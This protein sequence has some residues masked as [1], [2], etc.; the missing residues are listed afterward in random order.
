[1][2]MRSVMQR[3]IMQ[4]GPALCLRRS[5]A[6]V[7]VGDQS[8]FDKLESAG[9]K[10]IFYFTATWCPP[11][12]MI[13]PIFE[14]LAKVRT[15]TQRSW[16]SFVAS[17]KHAPDSPSFYPTSSQP[18]LLPFLR[19]QYRRSMR[20]WTS[21][22]WMWMTSQRLRA[23]TRCVDRPCGARRELRGAREM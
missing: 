13:A 12:R 5:L 8:G 9:G 15:Q 21:A 18:P 7:T 4:R 20:A 6:F 16:C 2:S 3:S 1:M 23:S 10:K 14:R 17:C 22:K 11:C 19:P